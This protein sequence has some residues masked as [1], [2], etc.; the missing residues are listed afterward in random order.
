MSK[1]KRSKFEIAVIAF[2][3]LVL[4]A[5]VAVFIGKKGCPPIPVPADQ[6]APV[7]NHPEVKAA[8]VEAP[9]VKIEIDSNKPDLGVPGAKL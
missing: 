8:P 1:D 3:A 9:P 7:V 5:V 2:L 4:I 6:P